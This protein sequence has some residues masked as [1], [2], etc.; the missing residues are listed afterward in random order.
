MSDSGF[1]VEH[2]EKA[3][4]F[5]V[6]TDGGTA[7]LRYDRPDDRTIGLRHTVVPEAAAGRGIGS[8]L[9]RAAFDYAR[10]SGLRVVVTCPF[11]TEWLQRHPEERDVVVGAAAAG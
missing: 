2:R 7:F 4:R 11:V 3:K 9:A 5:T 10:S 1:R 6:E 8:A